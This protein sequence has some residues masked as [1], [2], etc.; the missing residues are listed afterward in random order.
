MMAFL[1]S[2]HLPNTWTRAR[3]RFFL[4]LLFSYLYENKADTFESKP[5]L[6]KTRRETFRTNPS[7]IEYVTGTEKERERE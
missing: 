3:S 1:Q 4:S 2:A 6:K 5:A 7:G